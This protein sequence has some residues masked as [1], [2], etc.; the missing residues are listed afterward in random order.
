MLTVVGS[1]PCPIPILSRPS[2]LDGWVIDGGSRLWC[3]GVWCGDVVLI[4]NG[5]RGEMLLVYV[6]V[7]LVVGV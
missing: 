5:K 2:Y 4:V 6:Y 7:G 3:G 1:T